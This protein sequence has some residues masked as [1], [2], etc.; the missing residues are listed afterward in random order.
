MPAEDEQSSPVE[1]LLRPRPG[2]SNVPATRG[3]PRAHR[4]RAVLAGVLALGDGG[5]LALVLVVVGGVVLLVRNL[6][7]RREGGPPP[8]GPPATPP[9][10][11]YQTP[12]PT[13]QPQPT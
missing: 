4:R 12:L 3:R 8:P 13:Y 9:P 11:P 10:A 1:S 7:E 5:D 6:D 2:G